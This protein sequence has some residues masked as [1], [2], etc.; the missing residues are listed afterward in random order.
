MVSGKHGQLYP[1]DSEV[2]NCWFL[3]GMQDDLDSLV[4]LLYQLKAVHQV[5]V[6]VEKALKMVS[7]D[8]L[9]ERYNRSVHDCLE[10][11][12]WPHCMQGKG[13]CS[14]VAKAVS[15]FCAK[16]VRSGPG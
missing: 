10:S 13:S 2:R 8:L 15:V 5:C 3:S 1:Q 14:F 16:N 12:C 6:D 4:H 9:T 7:D 11:G